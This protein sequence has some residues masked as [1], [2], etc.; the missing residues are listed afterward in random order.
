MQKKS[1]R[2]SGNTN[3]A[4]EFYVASQLFRLGYEVTITLGHTKEIDLIVINPT[5]GKTITI[6]VKG[7]KNKSN[8]PLTPQ[9][10]RKDHFYVLVNYCN[11]FNDLDLNPIYLKANN[12]GQ[13]DKI[14][15]SNNTAN[16][17]LIN[18]GKI[19]TAAT[20][21]N[22]GIPYEIKEVVYFQAAVEVEEGTT[23][24]MQPS[25]KLIINGSGSLKLKGTANANITI[26]S[27]KPSPA[28]GD[29][30]EIDIY[31]SSNNDNV[32][33]YVNIM[34]GGSGSYGQVWV[35]KGASLTLNN[36]KFSEGRNCDLYVENGGNIVNNG[37]TYTICPQ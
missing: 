16:T 12:V 13:L 17:V 10:K 2:Q 29:W 22:M 32:W 27:S 37:S 18:G 5:N 7:L 14:E 6:D 30:K 31:A 23:I 11:K 9:L 25:E 19:T 3:L 1:K 26:K 8:W 24:L 20:W 4:S 33:S 15:T 36:C 21:K 35:E 28:S 34:H